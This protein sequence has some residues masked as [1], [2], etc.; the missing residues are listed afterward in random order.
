MTT[1]LLQPPPE[2]A[3]ASAVYREAEEAIRGIAALDSPPRIHILATLHREPEM[4]VKA[5]AKS[6]GLEQPTTSHHLRILLDAGLVSCARR[7]RYRVEPLAVIAAVQTALDYIG[8]VRR[9]EAPPT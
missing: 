1:T 8:I 6:I 4:R 3:E 2:K 9:E 7:G 5:L